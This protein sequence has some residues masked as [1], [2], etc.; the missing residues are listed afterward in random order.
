M[1]GRHFAGRK[2]SHI[3]ARATE[4]RWVLA[5]RR[6]VMLATAC[7]RARSA[8]GVLFSA[9]SGNQFLDD[10]LATPDDPRSPRQA[11][12]SRP[13]VSARHAFARVV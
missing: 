6:T 3:R 8:V 1:D 10:D 4:V 7:P 2:S 12:A 9:I 13:P 5:G 11:A